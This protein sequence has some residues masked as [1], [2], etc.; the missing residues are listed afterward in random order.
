LLGIDRL[1][2][3]S[4]YSAIHLLPINQESGSIDAKPVLNR[5]VISGHGIGSVVGFVTYGDDMS[6]IIAVTN[7]NHSGVTVEVNGLDGC[8]AEPVSSS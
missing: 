2:F 1:S 5:F 8:T 6:A 4:H 7:L 3:T